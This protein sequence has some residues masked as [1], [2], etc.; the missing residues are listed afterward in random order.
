MRVEVASQAGACYGVERALRLVRDSVQTERGQVHTLG[1]LIH[2][3]QVVEELAEAGVSPVS[4]P[5]D[6]DGGTL[7]LR[8]HGVTPQEERSASEH[9][10]R[11]INATCPFV[12]RAHQSARALYDQGY[13][14][15]IVGEK[16]HPEVMGTL[17]NAPGAVVVQGASELDGIK[18]GRRVGIVVQTTQARDNLRAIVSA[19]IGRCEELR[20]CDTICEATSSKQGAAAELSSRAD[21]MVVIGGRN[22]ANTTRLAKICSARCPRTHHIESAS[23]LQAG[24][25]D[26]ANL[27]GITA[28]ASTPQ[29]QID[30][31]R[32][33]VEG[34]G[35]AR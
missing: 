9:A 4:S 12:L 29:E 20:L 24:W 15:I 16:G 17:G 14:V 6:V 10:D 1:P 8:T 27:V 7:V 35:G 30:A 13:Q 22:S 26:G 34:M 11:V 23:E 33:A 3:P 21:V 2:N 19:L 18:V 31:V 32:S 25:F 28:G 5:E